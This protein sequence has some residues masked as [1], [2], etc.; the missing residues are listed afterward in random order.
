[1]MALHGGRLN[2]AV[3]ALDGAVGPGMGRLGQAV[4]HAV[5]A[6]DTVKAVP[7]GQQ[8]VRLR[9]ELNAVVGEHGT[10]PAGQFVQHP[11]QQLGRDHAL[12]LRMPFGK[13]DFAGSVNGCKQV[14][15]AF[16]GLDLGEVDVPVADGLVLALLLRRI[17]PVPAQGQSTDAGT[18]KTA[19]QGRARAPRNR[20]LERVQAVVERQQGV[21]PESAGNGFLCGGEHGRGRRWPHRGIRYG[22]A[23]TPYGRA[24]TPFSARFRV[25]AVAG[26]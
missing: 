3:H 21:L 12:G 26:R 18:L 2:Q 14:L 25:D 19:V 1:M 23:F 6:A 10:H 22:R 13:G 17:F 8:L 15:R 11:A 9:R 5:F 20:G 24:F 7:T 4:L 16:L